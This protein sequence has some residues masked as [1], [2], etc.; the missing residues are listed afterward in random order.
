M[1]F[2]EDLDVIDGSQD[3]I[4]SLSAYMRLNAGNAKTLLQVRRRC[5]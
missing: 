3:C 4:E 5:A 1:P 2:A